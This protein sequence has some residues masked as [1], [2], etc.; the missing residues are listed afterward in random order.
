M[1]TTTQAQLKARFDALLVA[2]GASEQDAAKLRA[3]FA[4]L[5]GE[6]L[7]PQI[8]GE[9]GGLELEPFELDLEGWG[10]DWPKLDDWDLPDLSTW[11]FDD[12]AQLDGLA[13]PSTCA[14][15]GQPLPSPG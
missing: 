14:L 10:W 9:V 15:C 6:V 3:D 13:K 8:K 7:D 1:M 12:L 2:A 5:L 11:D 4:G